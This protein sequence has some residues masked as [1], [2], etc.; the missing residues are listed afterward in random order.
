MLR[1]IHIKVN[2]QLE[3]FDGTFIKFIK[4][5]LNQDQC[6]NFSLPVML[7]FGFVNFLFCLF[8]NDLDY[9]PRSDEIN[10]RLG[11]IRYVFLRIHSI[12]LRLLNYQTQNQMINMLYE[13]KQKI[14]KP[15]SL[16]YIKKE[17][18]YTYCFETFCAPTYPVFVFTQYLFVPSSVTLTSLSSDISF[19]ILLQKSQ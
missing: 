7:S 11:L 6:T 15:K 16:T 5:I 9:L 13:L 12:I 4:R 1:C 17:Q 10:S 8:L 19:I 14:E 3:F 18:T 2:F